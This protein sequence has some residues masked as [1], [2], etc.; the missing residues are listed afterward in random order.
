MINTTGHYWHVICNKC[1]FS[2]FDALQTAVE[3]RHEAVTIATALD[4]RIDGDVVICNVCRFI[5]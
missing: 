1:D 2:L 5:G 3:N 4:W